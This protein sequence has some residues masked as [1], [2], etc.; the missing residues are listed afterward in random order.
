MTNYKDTLN[1]PR[2]SFPMRAKLPK[3]E[4]RILEQWEE[5]DAYSRMIEGK[6]DAP[7]FILHDGPPYANGHIH[8]GTAT[9]KIL[10]DIIV[11]SRN[12][13]GYK[14][15]YVPG[16]DC[17]GLPIELKVEQE[18]KTEEG[19][20]SALDI[21]KRC[22]EYALKYLDVQREEFKRLGAFGTWGEPYLTMTP[23]YQASIAGE[24]VRFVRTGA[25]ERRKKPIHWCP[26]CQTA[27]AEAEVE[28]HN[29]T[30]PSIYV[31]FPVTQ[32]EFFR[33]FPAAE[34]N[35]VYAL[36]WTTTPWTIPANL[37]IA[38]HPEYDYVLVRAG[39]GIYILAEKL[40]SECAERFGWSE[41]EILERF[42]G[43]ELDGFE[44]RHPLYDRSSLFVRADYVAMETGTG[45]VH[46][47]PGHG[48]E[49]YETG[50]KYGLSIYAPLDDQGRFFDEV[51]SFA[52]KNVFQADPDI[53]R[54]LDEQ[55]HLL[56]HSRMEH[57]YPHCWRCKKPVIFRATTQW[58]ISMDRTGLRDRALR[59]IERVNWIPAWGEQR[60]GSMVAGRP[61][62][63]I[64]RQRAW[65]VPIVALICNGC[66]GAYYDPDWADT[67]VARFAEHPRGADYWFEADAQD[68]A[69]EGLTCE[70]CGGEDFAKES[71]ILDVWF[72][73]GTSFAAVLEKRSDC[74]FPASLYLEGSDQH[75]G[76]FH[77]SLLASVGTRNTAPYECVLT[78][79]FVV[80]GE[81]KKM[82][83]SMGNVIAPQ[84]IIEQYGAE[85]LRIWTA[86]ENYQ[87]DMRISQEILGQLVDNYR[88]I[89]NTCR[90]ILGNLS[91]FDP[92]EV[93]VGPEN[94][95]PMDRYA[96][97][98]IQDRHR[99]ILD[100]YRSYE[101]HKVFHSLHGICVSE[102]SAFY[103]D[104]LKDRL[105]V[106]H[107]DSLQRRSAQSA[108]Y[109]ILL[110][111]LRDMAPILSFTAEEIHNNLPDALK[112]GAS[113]VFGLGLPE[114]EPPMEEQEK[115]FWDLLLTLRGEVSKAVEPV[116]REG[117]VGHSLDC[118][119]TL[120][121]D[122]DLMTRLQH[123][124]STLPELCIVSQMELES[125]QRAPEGAYRSE[126]IE[127]LA[128]E[129]EPAAGEKCPRCWHYSQGIGAN[130]DHPEVC[131]RCADVM[132]L[133]QAAERG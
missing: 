119:V 78:H 6:E 69:P 99:Y 20:G 19:G 89:R 41:P 44:A 36:I 128:V 108:L 16:W 130:E 86:S 8:L 94:M 93:D 112:P 127:G 120:Y 125:L 117:T 60:I 17:H 28:Y 71:D 82:S 107:K 31:R 5:V 39:D 79:G 96:L 21:R 95:L 18:Q 38:L 80:D 63:C 2:T 15:E 3:S 33:R 4:P 133:L 40:L 98:L 116:R 85:I 45:C 121:A 61:D 65:G 105:Y 10:K 73:S 68:L 50:R 70:H 42:R 131:P 126:E 43:G 83:K 14:A 55:G 97:Q 132:R 123:A 24:F 64:S 12:M 25:V 13:L 75:R 102:L 77:S 113:T 84:E 88:R 52:G 76:W 49:D 59:E 110:L 9:N 47:A 22:R 66:G 7:R 51:G 109:R 111:L 124:E 37:A 58:F 57:S 26:S 106:S 115:R 72:D 103:L 74:A 48:Q 53:I 54:I 62:W 81:G 23:E 118:R 1:L 122:E 27:L 29:R 100:A 11:K 90:F 56:A 46:T 34:G 30:S 129:V 114:A 92:A 104:V 101:L 91:D 35:S 67:V 87:E 32:P